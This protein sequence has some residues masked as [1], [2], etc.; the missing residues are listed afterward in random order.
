MEEP[1]R[2]ESTKH[3]VA[4]VGFV[5]DVLILLYLLKSG[6]SIRIREF[7]ENLSGSEWVI[8]ATYTLVIISIF[9]VFDL[10]LSL[11]S[12]YFREHHFGLSRQSLGGWIKDQ[13]KSL[14]I[15][16]VLSI[17]AVEVIYELLRTQADHWWI[18]ASIAF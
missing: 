4:I 11:Y 14:A 2:Y 5:L 17:G 10:P 12:G 9:R 6:A 18:Y 13:T 3:V 7:A 8:V 15:A 1:K 16:I